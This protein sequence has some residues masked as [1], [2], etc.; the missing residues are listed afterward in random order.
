[1]SNKKILFRRGNITNLPELAAGELG[2]TTDTGQV[3]VGSDDRYGS[4]LENTNNIEVLTEKSEDLYSRLHG[5]LLRN[6]HD[7]NFYYSLLDADTITPTPIRVN[8]SPYGISESYSSISI[9]YHVVN[10]RTGENI[11]SGELILF[12]SDSGISF[13][14][15]SVRQR[16]IGGAQN[17]YLQPNDV[18]DIVKFSFTTDD[19]KINMLY[20]NY[21]FDNLVCKFRVVRLDETGTQNTLNSQIAITPTIKAEFNPS[22]VRDTLWKIGGTDTNGL[23]SAFGIQDN[24]NIVIQ[25]IEQ[26]P[27]GVYVGARIYDSNPAQLS[28]PLD[29]SSI[30]A[31]NTHYGRSEI[32]DLSGDIP[33]RAV[34]GYFDN[35]GNAIWQ[36]RLSGYDA[37]NFE[38]IRNSSGRVSF[39][40]SA[41][42]RNITDNGLDIRIY[43]GEV[44]VIGES[45]ETSSYRF[46]ERVVNS[47]AQPNGDTIYVTRT[48][49]KRKNSVG[50]N[51]W[52][53]RIAGT[54][55]DLVSIYTAVMINSSLI[56][57]GLINNSSETF[58]TSLSLTGNIQWHKTFAV[59]N[60]PHSG[61]LS[62]PRSC[63]DI[64]ENTYVARYY[65]GSLY[66][67]K[68]SSAGALEWSRVI[69]HPNGLPID[70]QI[71]V[72]G[73][74]LLIV[75]PA[76]LIYII[77]LNTSSGTLK[78]SVLYSDV[79]D[80]RRISSLS[81]V[82]AISFSYVSSSPLDQRM[83]YAGIGRLPFE[84]IHDNE[85]RNHQF[86]KSFN[87]TGN[88]GVV[89]VQDGQVTSNAT[90]ITPYDGLT[91]RNIDRR[92][93]NLETSGSILSLISNDTQ[94]LD[95]DTHPHVAG[96]TTEGPFWTSFIQGIQNDA[97]T[98]DKLTPTA[99]AIRNSVIFVAMSAISGPS[100]YIVVYRINSSGAII[101]RYKLGVSTPMTVVGM[102][103]TS[104]NI[105]V[106]TSNGDKINFNSTGSAL[107]SNLGYNGFD[108]WTA[109]VLTSTAQYTI[110]D[111]ATEANIVRLHSTTNAITSQ[112]KIQE[113]DG[114]R[115]GMVRATLA[116]LISGT[117]I[118]LPVYT[119]GIDAPSTKRGTTLVK[120]NSAYTIM[121]SKRFGSTLA[122]T[123]FEI[124][125]VAIS[126]SNVFVMGYL[127]TGVKTRAS[128]ILKLDQNGNKLWSREYHLERYNGEHKGRR[129]LVGQDGKLFHVLISRFE[130]PNVQHG[131]TFMEI[132]ALTG[133]ILW[134]RT[135]LPARNTN[136][137]TAN[138]EL[139]DNTIVELG[140]VTR[141][142]NEI[143]ILSRFP[144]GTGV[145]VDDDGESQ[146]VVN[147]TESLDCQDI[148]ISTG[149]IE[150]V[151]D[152]TITTIV[153]NNLQ[154]ISN[155]TRNNIFTT[156]LD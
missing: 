118:Y 100:H 89:R 2:V 1:M 20:Q 136:L 87:A 58:V 36:K 68:F 142:V 67:L 48:N 33:S 132:D 18:F 145:S 76:G 115:V 39:V 130:Y 107:S 65:N 43:G 10:N 31:N 147:N 83:N 26:T 153:N 19:D 38:K 150:L 111:Y 52:S 62:Y 129:I 95:F 3:F 139:L 96:F 110:V 23:K 13:S 99:V 113:R 86:A 93:S 29:G 101:T 28:L 134:S 59:N 121:W 94:G 47:F 73:D 49:I 123:D 97:L 71:T 40:Y 103:V 156:P 82:S 122:N 144:I 60:M 152:S 4:P 135:V 112:R 11:R 127:T 22:P 155:D 6:G 124:L 91:S 90:T 53:Y 143:G 44:D 63:S 41:S 84:A 69:A 70:Y 56:I 42:T 8:Q 106:T 140:A 77:C 14:D 32:A 72:Y 21:T 92:S 109:P 102:N 98:W 125:D 154:T 24:A 120:T 12:K 25:A 78:D 57:T 149:T 138:Y 35:Y 66:V 85:H 148:S 15:S 131:R 64:N 55:S 133:D 61:L 45:Y 119:S 74:N 141:G 146:W 128:V 51:L 75:V 151:T 17:S 9:H 108:K 30:N 117:D 50:T 114:D 79:G 105:I 104:S 116:P 27:D 7:G 137:T 16:T 88:T 5:E 54:S 81:S 126:G 46:N 37:V 80:I 34:L